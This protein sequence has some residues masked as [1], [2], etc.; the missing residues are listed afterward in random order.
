MN[1]AFSAFLDEFV[2]NIRNS[3]SSA[4]ARMEIAEE[5]ISR[6]KRNFPKMAKVIDRA[7]K[8][9]CPTDPIR[10]KSD[11]VYRRH[12]RELLVRAASGVDLRPPTSVELLC[13]ALDSSLKAPLGSIGGL[14]AERLFADVFPEKAFSEEVHREPW[15]RAVEDELATL[16][17]KF[18]VEDRKLSDPR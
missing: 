13:V 3:V 16:R 5:E 8:A 18:A 10:A 2:P 17:R 15:P 1:P 12:A 9:L 4:F 7:F 11:E 6:A 14:L